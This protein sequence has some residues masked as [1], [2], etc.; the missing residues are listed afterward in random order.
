MSHIQSTGTKMLTNQLKLKFLDLASKLSSENLSCDGERN[1]AEQ[2]YFY[3]IYMKQ[4][5]TL[6]RLAGVKVDEEEPYN[7]I[8]EL[9]ELKLLN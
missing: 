9:R 1:L 8:R 5:D 4:W 3:N 2:Q 6:E 7:W